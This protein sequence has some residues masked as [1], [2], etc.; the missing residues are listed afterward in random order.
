MKNLTRLFVLMLITTLAF[1]C[2]D[3]KKPESK[4]GS[5]EFRTLISS[6]TSGVI[7]AKSTVLVTLAKPTE[8]FQPGTELPGDLFRFDPAVSGKAY[9][10]DPVTIEFRPG[11]PF[12][13][14]ETYDVFFKI[15][16]LLNTG[17]SPEV[18]DFSF[19]V[20]KQ[21]FTVYPGE[22]TASGTMDN[23]EKTY[24][25]KMVTADDMSLEDASKIM[26]ASIPGKALSV[27]VTADSPT[28]FT[29]KI[30]G[31]PRKENSYILTIYSLG[32]AIG[33][34]KTD[35]FVVTIPGVDEFKLLQVNTDQS[36]SNQHIKLVFSDPIDP[37]QNLDGLIRLKDFKNY[38]LSAKG[39][40]VTIYPQERM[41]GEETVIVEG[42]LRNVYGTTL[43]ETKEY[44]VAME[45][46]KPE[47]TIL[48]N[49][50]IMPDSRDLVVPFKTVS[51][52]AVDV[53]VYKIY[54][55]N[56]QQF[57][58]YN[59]YNG[60]NQ[61]SYVG[62]PVYRKMV[63]LDQNPSTN[64]QQWNAFSVDLTEM[65][66]YD[67]SAMYRIKIAFRK[68]YSVY[69]C[70][71]DQSSDLT[72]FEDL[73]LM[74]VAENEYFEGSRSYYSDY[75][76]NY[77]WRDRDNPCS[78]SYYISSRFPERNLLASNLGIIAKSA[79][80]RKFTV[81]VTNLLTT[82]PVVSA[83]VEFYNLQQQKI[84]I[85][86]TDSDGIASV[87]LPE[88]PYLLLARYNDQQSWLRVDDGSS[89]S[90]SNFD[91]SGQ[92]IN[93]GIKGMIYGERGVW[94]PGDTL[95]LTF[96]M[97]DITNKLPENH[98]VVLELYNS[99]GQLTKREVQTTGIDGFYT[100]RPVTD[101]EAP[102]GKWTAKIKVGGA[103]FTKKLNIETIK[104]NRLKINLTFNR[105]IL[106]KNDHSQRA[107][108]EVK[109]LHG[110]VAANLKARVNVTMYETDYKFKK[111]EEYT[112]TDPSRNYYPS[113][114]T[115]F[116]GKLDQQGKASFEPDMPTNY[117]APGMLKAM[118]NTRVFEEGGDFS[119]D[120]FSKY[121]APYKRFVGVYVPEGGD[122]K[123]KLRTDTSHRVKVVVVNQDGLP[124][125]AND[126]VVKVYRVNWRWWWSS[127]SDNLASWV[128]GQNS[129]VVFSKTI[130]T[131]NGEASFDFQVD[132]P[133]WGRYLVQVSDLQGGHSTGIP[134]YIDWPSYYSR[135]NRNNPAG[136]TILSVSTDRDKYHPGDQAILSFPVSD[137]SRA[138]ISL[139]TGS[140]VLKYWW[141]GHDEIK[142]GFRFEITGDMAPNVFAC[143][144]L[145]QPH[146]QTAND[147]PIRM[148]GIVPVLVED[149]AT[150]LEPVIKAP[151]EIRPKAK[152][153][154][155]VS[156]KNGQMMT[157]TL[158]VVD[159]G[160]LDLTRF[161]TP[162]PWHEFY[163]REALGVK[164]WDLFD[165]VLG[166][167]GGRLQ[168]V[169]A[170][171]GDGAAKAEEGKKPN[172]FKPVVDFLGPFTLEAGETDKHQLT[173]PNY[174]GSVRVM[175]VAGHDG[176]YGSADTAVPV[177]QPLMVLPTAPRVIGPD[178][179]FSLPVSV[180]VMKDGIKDV[181]VRVK[182]TGPIRVNGES[183]ISLTYDQMGDQMAYF[184]LKA[185][186][187]EG[188]SKIT[189]T[190]TSGN[191][192][193]SAEI[194]LGVVN[195]NEFTTRS[196]SIVLEKGASTT[197]NYDFFGTEGTNSGTLEVS[198]MPSIDLEKN[199]KYLIRYPYGCVEQTTSSVF[200]QLYL[201]E[202]TELSEKQKQTISRNIKAAI[203]KLSRFQ[204]ANGGMSY[205]PGRNYI[206][207]WGTTYAWHFLLLAEQKGY[208]VPMNMKNRW[209]DW[210]Y[211]EASDFVVNE[212][213]IH[214][215]YYGM[216]QAY[217]LYTLALA[218]KP[219]LS[220]MNR[221]RESKN[222]TSTA[223]WRLAAAYVLAGLPEAAEE[224]TN[225]LSYTEVSEYDSPGWTYGSSLR[226]KAMILEV[227]VLM[228]KADQAWELA[229]MMA[230]EMQKS[231]LS[232][233][234]AAYSL[235]A[236]AR[237]AEL[238][239]DDSE[240][241]FSYQLNGNQEEV[242]T[243]LPVYT[244]EIA[245]NGHTADSVILTNLTENNLF[246][247]K[248]ISGKPLQGKETNETKN[249]EMTIEYVG[250]DGSKLDVSNLKQGTDFE[251]RVTIKNP[252][253]MGDYEN[254][255]LAQVF[256]SGWEI[257]NLRY[258]EAGEEENESNY[259]YRD[260][261]DDRVYT[262]FDLKPRYKVTF[263]VKLNA[264]YAGKFYLPGTICHAMY[265]NRIYADEKGKW[266][267]VVK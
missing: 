65:I 33:I 151:D 28:E 76:D 209:L 218:G 68:A 66:G 11:K 64:L 260:V 192:S 20:I 98:P 246:V 152:Y 135:K 142:N 188:A 21:D 14:G 237:F 236:L 163:A 256:P 149:P 240:N 3:R 202:L 106:A 45:A 166:A 6:H 254:L 173:M 205:W 29:Y 71:D 34:D 206:S 122:Y 196:E 110:A 172:R 125:D 222:L 176:A 60:E 121:F 156:E 217:R 210:Q 94:R 227:L 36:A 43:D 230:K 265:D 211:S 80:G 79:D 238:S 115:I 56:I 159:E 112:F 137:E 86:L 26:S 248:T 82:E 214:Y 161:K 63:R 245:E 154:I 75:P 140:E 51:L 1:S 40:T 207:R 249:L 263:T 23:P 9:L 78:E 229:D 111:Y 100:F 2:A 47:V 243:G 183:E 182:T 129:D 52:R 31:I 180:F 53:L 67:N 10:L 30:D 89:L 220:A 181:T 199:L 253:Q 41:Y 132:Y 38:K 12:K 69:D 5:T 164:T 72:A 39:T 91:V 117:N 88:M 133:E 42:T 134:V 148:Y 224:M 223:T 225:N 128:R 179:E 160:L 59:Q 99:R 215:R 126:L 242:N 25:G 187:K 252:G 221:L 250:I 234:T 175:V 144:M 103:S 171:G 8:N 185:D 191:E 120:V 255:A 104:P 258:T 150:I 73:K 257:L 147:L 46:L 96:V 83:D 130:S 212:D 139:E 123:H 116:D 35:K 55:G 61:L 200:P 84:G 174:V 7:S 49:G 18:Y 37:D 54:S 186:Q 92:K 32:N 155:S 239:G 107:S 13:N 141:A 231:Y 153:E 95:F 17:K 189:V 168:K 4:S 167:Y 108:L 146:A 264:A 114:K 259:D 157:Y 127:G 138:L 170:I 105:D 77:S 208:L 143:V 113:E 226:D 198:T 247:T 24:E 233:Q 197:V 266:I 190:A 204:T 241:H 184:K 219:N 57:F 158:A 15:G 213:Y 124:V 165:E 251:A 235:F 262:F 136:A 194:D 48:G 50:V 267:E 90:V 102:T 177:R 81:A 201:D 70:G 97:D 74:S 169:L 216:S 87:S 19:R 44:Q 22:L 62:R 195:P 118:F 228:K 27:K 85:G 178:E 16:E 232:T 93:E 58:Q 101:A 109:W 131:T 244:I 119:T 193:A 203:R 162:S 145:I 261:R